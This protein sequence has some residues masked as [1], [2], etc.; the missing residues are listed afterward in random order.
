MLSRI[1][2][3]L[4]ELL[5]AVVVS[6]TP[7]AVLE[8]TVP[9]RRSLK[10]PDTP[11]PTALVLAEFQPTRLL[12]PSTSMPNWLAPLARNPFSSWPPVCTNQP[13]VPPTA[14]GP[15]IVSLPVLLR[16]HTGELLLSAVTRA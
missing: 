15:M 3:P 14:S 5:F 4:R 7:P 16:V 11:S 12:L 9:P 2:A 10:P 8:A 1:V 13:T 6:S